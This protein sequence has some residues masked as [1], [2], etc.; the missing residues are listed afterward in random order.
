MI[1]ICYVNEDYPPIIKLIVISPWIRQ[2]EYQFISTHNNMSTVYYE[3]CHGTFWLE[4]PP[5]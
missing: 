4:N 1:R 3:N 2:H 5:K